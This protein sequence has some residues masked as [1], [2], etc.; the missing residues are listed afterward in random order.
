MC[1]LVNH[2]LYLAT[3]VFSDSWGLWALSI[4]LRRWL[5][6]SFVSTVQLFPTSVSQLRVRRSMSYSSLPRLILHPVPSALLTYFILVQPSVHLL[7]LKC[8][9]PIASIIIALKYPGLWGYNTKAYFIPEFPP[10]TYNKGRKQSLTSFCV[11]MT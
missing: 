6:P 3:P 2:N 4:T 1:P 5:T 7:A 9:Q 10:S 11:P 8:F